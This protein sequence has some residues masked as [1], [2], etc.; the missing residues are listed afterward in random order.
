MDVHVCVG[1]Y[2]HTLT[3]LELFWYLVP[4][5]LGMVMLVMFEIHSFQTI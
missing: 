2:T 1:V 5:L 4:V 3:A